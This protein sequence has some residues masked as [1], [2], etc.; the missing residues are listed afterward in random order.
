MAGRLRYFDALHVNSVKLDKQQARGK[1]FGFLEATCKRKKTMTNLEL[2]MR[3]LP[4][5]VLLE[6]WVETWLALRDWIGLVVNDKYPF[7]TM[8]NGQYRGPCL[9]E[10]LKQDIGRS[11]VASAFVSGTEHRHAQCHSDG[12]VVGGKVWGFP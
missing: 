5:A 7:L 9:W 12:L 10:L 2:R 4:V 11:L 8:A 1:V 3:L 6:S